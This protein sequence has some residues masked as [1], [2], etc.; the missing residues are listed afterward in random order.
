MK[1]KASVFIDGAN[2][3]YALRREGWEIDFKKF[4]EYFHRH[5]NIQKIFYYEGQVTKSFYFDTHPNATLEDFKKAKER[6]QKFFK[7]LKSY[8]IIVRS[9]PITRVYDSTE[10]RL[11]HKCNFDVELTIDAIHTISEYKIFILCSGD[12]DFVKLL[13]YLKG[14]FKKTVLIAPKDR[15]SHQLEN[16]ANQIIYLHYI[17]E[18]IEIK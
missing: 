14:H 12:G 17:R 4:V 7:L 11:K 2:Y 15:I 9:K 6:K 18:N 8:G 10:G 3:H 1:N 16:T 13:K 5:Y